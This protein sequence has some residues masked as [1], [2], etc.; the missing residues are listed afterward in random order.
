MLT[1]N[2]GA[3]VSGT[4]VEAEPSHQSSVTFCCRETDGSRGAV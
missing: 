2:I 3:D 1:H 4:V